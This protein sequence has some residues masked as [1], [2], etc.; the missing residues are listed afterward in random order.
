MSDASQSLGKLLLAGGFTFLTG[1]FVHAMKQNSKALNEIQI[2][3]NADIVNLVGKDYDLKENLIELKEEV[4]RLP[5]KKTE[6]KEE[7]NQFYTWLVENLCLLFSLSVQL[8][9]N[10]VDYRKYASD[11]QTYSVRINY[12]L[13]ELEKRSQVNANSKAKIHPLVENLKQ[14]AKDYLHNIYVV[15]L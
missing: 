7:T 14:K 5:F 4:N 11:A 13:C 15:L 9:K 2:H 10:V 6:E 1:A 3:S 12:Y 8:N